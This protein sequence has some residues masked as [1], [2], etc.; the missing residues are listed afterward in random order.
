MSN[1]I[2]ETEVAPEMVSFAGADEGSFALA[3]A[4]GKIMMHAKPPISST[5]SRTTA[6]FPGA[7]SRPLRPWRP[8]GASNRRFARI[9]ATG[10]FGPF[11]AAV[12]TLRQTFL[13]APHLYS[14]R[15]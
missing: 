15:E 10:P 12:A 3:D 4:A 6:P 11:R 13:S 9:A 2:D 7:P 5:L 1:G 8:H 14:P